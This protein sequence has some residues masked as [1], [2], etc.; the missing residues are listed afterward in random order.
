MFDNTHPGPFKAVDGYT[1]AGEHSNIAYR[2]GD[3]LPPDG[4]NEMWRQ[5]YV[6]M[7]SPKVRF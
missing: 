7:T 5:T 4:V 3:E 6:D 1:I 2:I